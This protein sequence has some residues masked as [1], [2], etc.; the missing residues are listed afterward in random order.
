MEPSPVTGHED[1]Q[2]AVTCDKAGTGENE[3]I[4]MGEKW[5]P[6]SGK[7]QEPEMVKDEPEKP[8]PAGKLQRPMELWDMLGN[9]FLEYQESCPFLILEEQ[10]RRLWALNSL[11]LK[12]CNHT[13][14]VLSM[15]NIQ[16]FAK[17]LSTMLAVEL[18]KKISNKPAEEARLAIHRF[19]QEGGEL[20]KQGFLLLKSIYILSQTDQE[21]LWPIV[22]SGLPDVYLQCLYLFFAFPLDTGQ[23]GPALG[24]DNLD[25]SVQEMFT[26]TMM[27][28]CSQTEGVEELLKTPELQSLIT[29][30]ISLWEQSC[31]WWRLPTVR[32][33]RAVSRAQTSNTI[34][35]LHASCCLKMAVRELSSHACILPLA[36]LC[37]VT[38]LLLGFLKDSSPLSMALLQ[39]F[40]DNE[41]YPLIVTILLRCEGDSMAAV[42][43]QLD[44]LLSLLAY[45]TTCGKTELK[46]ASSVAH[47]Q[48]P[49]FQ[50]Q[51]AANSGNCVKNLQAFQVLQTVFQKSKDACLCK[52][53]LY[54]M[55]TI[56]AMDKAN[57]FLL[58]WTLQP[59]SQFV[60]KINLYD[61]HVQVLFFQLIEFIVLELSYIPH[62]ILRKIQGLIKESES[63][64][65]TIAALECILRITQRDQLFSDIFRDS[66]LLGTLL[67]Q[68]RK[69]A[70]LLR[71]TAGREDGLAP[72]LEAE[73]GLTLVRLQAVAALIRGSIRN[74]VVI[75]DYGMVPYIKIFLDMACYRSTSLQILEQLSVINAEEYMS[76]VI[77][78][79]CSSTQGES[80]L[81]LD[82]LGSL[83]R[84]LWIPKARSAFRTASGFNGLLSVLSEMEGALRDP[85]CG[86]WSTIQP[87]HTLELVKATMSGISAAL[88]QDVVNC[89]FFR[90]KRLFTKLAEDLQLLGCFC[91]PEQGRAMVEFTERRTF[92]EFVHLALHSETPFP[93]SLKNCIALSCFLNSIALG[94]LHLEASP[95]E[96][97]QP[98]G[99]AFESACTGAQEGDNQD[100]TG[101]QINRRTSSCSLP[102]NRLHST[103]PEIVHPGAV[104]ALVRL[105]PNI[106]SDQHPELS[107]E[108]QCAVA[109]HIQSLVKSEKNRQLMCEGGLLRSLVT[110][111]Q[112]PLGDGH[113]PLHLPLVRVFE[114][115]ASQAVDPDVLRQFLGFALSPDVSKQDPESGPPGRSISVSEGS[116]E[117]AP[118]LEPATAEQLKAQ[119]DADLPWQPSPPAR[120]PQIDVSLVS[121]TS[122]RNFQFPT[123]DGAPSFIEFDM[124]SS[125]HGGLFLPT[126]GTILGAN[127]EH[128]FSGGI[129][130]GTRGFPPQGGLCFSAWFLVSRFG[131]ASDAHP[132][133][134]LTIVRHMS[135]AEQ[136]FVCLSI[137][138]SSSD[139]SLVI[140]TEEEEFQLLDMMELE[141]LDLPLPPAPSKAQFDVSRLLVARQWQHLSVV[142][143]KD[144]KRTCTV[145]AFIDTEFVGSAK[146]LYIQP[147]AGPSA[148]LESSS[149]LDVYAY[150]STPPVWRQSSSLLWRLGPTY[151]FE[152]PLPVE[153]LE[154]IYK[155]GPTYCGSFQG[156]QDHGM[157]CV[158]SATPT[159]LIAEEKIS[160]GINACSASWT[161]IGEIKEKFNDV[162]GRLIAKEMG[163]DSR[164][165]LTPVCLARNVAAHLSGPARSIGAASV[166]HKGLRV[167]H[168]S[169]AAST[170][171][172]VGGPAMLLGLIAMARD[173]HALYAAVKVLL[174]VLGSSVM[175]R[176]LMNHMA[177]YQ[178]LAFLL[179]KKSRLLNR[180]ILQLLFS[181]TGTASLNFGPSTI[182]SP[183]AFQALLCDFELW[184]NAPDNLDFAV[185]SHLVDVLRSSSKKDECGDAE[186]AQQM[187]LVPKLTFLLNDPSIPRPKVTIICTILTHLLKGHFNTKD[188]LR[189]GLFL[190]YTLHP[191][192]VDEK[193]IRLET[194]SAADTKV[195]GKVSAR[196]LWL[197]QQ[198]LMVMLQVICVDSDHLPL[199]KQ[200]EIYRSLGPDWFLLFV[201]S[202]LHPSTVEL[203]MRLLVHFLHHPALLE[204][205]K[206]VVKAGSWLRNSTTDMEILMDNLKSKPLAPVDMP[207][208]CFHLLS[209]F[210]ML[211][212][213][214]KHHVQNL[215]IYRLLAG[216]FL[217]TPQCG[218]AEELQCTLDLALQSVLQSHSREQVVR[219]GLC[220]E[221]ALLLLEMVNVTIGKP[222]AALK[223]SWEISYPGSV[224]QFLCLVYHRYPCDPLWINADFLQTLATIVFP[225]GVQMDIFDAVIAAENHAANF[226]NT[227][228]SSATQSVHPARK[229]VCDFMRLL[230]MESLLNIPARKQSHPLDQLLEASV[231]NCT[232]EQKKSFQTEILLSTINIF[233]IIGQNGGETISAR[234]RAGS[235]SSAD[236]DLADGA[237]STIVGNIS[238]FSQKL[239]DKLNAGMFIADPKQIL[240]FITEQITTVVE[241]PVNQREHL[242]SSLYSSLNRT[243]LYCLSGARQT[244]TDL[245]NLQGLLKVLMERWDIVFATYNSNMSFI[246]CFIHCL[247]QIHSGSY[248]E[249][250][251]ID[252]A[253]HPSFWHLIFRDKIDEVDGEEQPVMS[254]YDVQVEVLKMVETVWD[255]LISQRRLALE[256]TYKMYL[257][258]KPGQTESGLRITDVTPLWEEAAAK[259]W[260]HYLASEKKTLTN[261]WTPPRGKTSSSHSAAMRMIQ[262]RLSKGTEGSIQDFSTC[263]DK[264]WRSAQDVFTCL[265]EDH[266]QKLHCSARNAANNWERVRGQL[267]SERGP[268]GPSESQNT[269]NMEL[270]IHEG[271]ARMR[272]RLKLHPLPERAARSKQQIHQLG[273]LQDCKANQDIAQVHTLEAEIS[274]AK[275]EESTL[276]F[277]PALHDGL[278]SEEL[279]HQ[280]MEREILMQEF[281]E[282]EKI[283]EKFSVALVKG[284]AVSEGVLLFGKD[285]FYTCQDF[286][287]SPSGDVCCIRHCVS[288]LE[289]SFIFTL[290]HNNK[291]KRSEMRTAGRESLPRGTNVQPSGNVTGTTLRQ[292]GHTRDNTQTGS[293]PLST[294]SQASTPGDPACQRHS[295]HEVREIQLMRFLLQDMALEIFFKN[296]YSKFLVFPNKDRS[297]ATKRFCSYQVHLK[298]KGV[299][300][301]SIN[302]SLKITGG[303]KT[304]LQKWQKGEMS[305]FEYLMFL[306]TESGRT[307]NDYMQYPVFPWII[308]DYESETLDLCD[309]RTFRDLSKPMGAQTQDR[310]L[311]FVKRYNEVEKGDF[312]VQ[313]HYCTHYSSASIVASYLMRL[314]P[315]TSTLCCL[316]GGTFD[317]AD[318]MFHSVRSTWNSASREN[319]S[320]VRELIPEFF[321]LPEFLT[322][323]NHCQF[324]SM[325]DGTVLGD[326]LLPPW[327]D[328]DPDN[329][330]RL[331]RQ[332]LECDYV[333]ANLHH[334][335]D[336][337]FGFKQTGPAAADAVNVFHPYFYGDN[338]DLRNRADPLLHSTILGFVSNFGQI[339]KQL[340]HKP[341]PSRIVQGRIPSRR[342]AA[343][344]V[345]SMG[346]TQ[347]FFCLPQSLKATQ[348]SLKEILKGPVGQIIH[349]EKNIFAVET[350]KVLIP[351]LW[352]K[353]FSWG[354]NDFSCS[355]GSYGSDK[356]IRVCENLAD[357]GQCLCAVCPSASTVITAGSSS[358]V[359]VWELSLVKDKLRSLTLKQALYG[360][361][362]AVTCL[363]ASLPYGVLVSGSSDHTCIIWDLD[364]LT[365][366][367]QL[368]GH[369]A[370]ISALA[371]SDASG[372]I[373]SCTRSSLHLWTINGRPLTSI[374]TA[375]GPGRGILCCCF[376]EL[377]EWDPRSVLVTGCADGVIRLWRRQ[378]ARTPEVPTP[379][380][381][382]VPD[383]QKKGEAEE[384]DPRGLELCAE[385]RLDNSQDGRQRPRLPA[386]TALA[387]S[388]NH[389]KLLAGDK[390]GKLYC[391]SLDG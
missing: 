284:H 162:D 170:L 264:C 371:I 52:K 29:A 372:H 14:G 201:Q 277:F 202:H 306:N 369:P 318:R 25:L 42:E 87:H 77:G 154:V 354:F 19:L 259:A 274:E 366:V 144:V 171:N 80:Q 376:S 224:M 112:E 276:T 285:H 204:K 228:S 43:Q 305:N 24:M 303:E 295:Y 223:D 359:C 221:A 362:K 74:A 101:G 387:V 219:S 294:G 296:G 152:E 275:R 242:F 338:A 339:P 319:M 383:N 141:T 350:N 245:L 176:Q 213:F 248:P 298:G 188:I 333:S 356:V 83:L 240:L 173:D 36:G 300:D 114:K 258:V 209:G 391:W 257:S 321:Y 51:H 384:R 174:S 89:E 377:H 316:Q 255:L 65:C 11:F 30:T 98:C 53:M 45:L 205:F 148:F 326:V 96:R 301:D 94:S 267:L 180:R 199:S 261:K 364:L 220:T 351:P 92:Q 390:N 229:Q 118:L 379:G 147:M 132:I 195:C 270:S 31:S 134:F 299:T 373:F 57:F 13:A 341:H 109:D 79:L 105:L 72:E 50:V 207:E 217:Q 273:V 260:Q 279:F 76:T 103:D 234:G 332:A 142:L 9:Q 3:G 17:E 48:L 231:E 370:K 169:P 102:G 222:P 97:K 214:L 200:E 126:V 166:G 233:H 84:V 268:W 113:D 239:V 35:Y 212:A 251:G 26:Q 211:Q 33:L 347:L 22:R 241:V 363:A 317:V 21:C 137:S 348:V 39:Q 60:E 27:S 365:Y 178:I 20:E 345:T 361:T 143:T 311:Q 37:E 181:I 175:S 389:T 329:F 198:L 320:D 312:Q 120:T 304:M 192:S 4:K 108:I 119:Q 344:T 184:L 81:R 56:W 208:P 218:P 237:I 82:T 343:T 385:L 130:R 353:I 197:R 177:G 12:A 358:V 375:G 292:A 69:Q 289:D 151:L 322:N 235:T 104:C 93:S 352:N 286:T 131:E 55:R 106:H 15:P 153:T 309:P 244:L 88:H 278:R 73:R 206:D 8:V 323:S 158:K 5:G 160:W 10:Q 226:H 85:P 107:M 121:M 95:N 122:P 78:V 40:E 133:R 282:N 146:I 38:A 115:L 236:L 63:P 313:C 378:S 7:E 314:E 367:C 243:I 99:E 308:A 155:L 252:A 18:R 330:I 167:F 68:L 230:L 265:Y 111:C 2:A 159:P 156:L 290:Y 355:L 247:F 254:E 249:G 342:D 186:T 291:T 125:G 116:P 124:S 386:V 232:V 263:L 128:S 140:S 215:Q 327:A 380:S 179:K 127:A 287:F 307:Y 336:L 283:S 194:L 191:S 374:T 136:Q 325:Q 340:F 44:D 67:T 172:F 164:D 75:K 32:V 163:I 196:T 382:S 1:V 193:Q 216:L 272:K 139:H 123:V 210:A 238:Y 337:I 66:G 324:G 227:G 46:V 262:G 100:C 16:I 185:F 91:V 190:I 331:H 41:G 360:H 280:C 47:P 297:K 149:F 23:E 59:I 315:F 253:S 64:L 117:T 349:T 182:E 168:S 135:R 368:P 310:M 6:D 54:T 250:F 281:A 246:T 388:R 86:V 187:D 71:K 334:W 381:G 256:D 271:P 34:H 335:I 58:E 62:E 225:S 183:S 70:K 61:A 269:G 189:V 357:W 157:D 266:L 302:F 328:G 110:H 28:V 129:G 49:D 138:I 145:T 346:H 161:S 90:S 165:N 150:I 293:S 203:G 288:S